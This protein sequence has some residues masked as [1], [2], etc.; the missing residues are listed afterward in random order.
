MLDVYR[1]AMPR[2]RIHVAQSMS[3]IICNGATTVGTN[4]KARAMP[5]YGLVFAVL[6]ND[7]VIGIIAVLLVCYNGVWY[8]RVA[9]VHIYGGGASARA[10]PTNAQRASKCQT[11]L[12]TGNDCRALLDQAGQWQWQRPECVEWLLTTP[13]KVLETNT[14]HGRAT[15]Y[16]ASHLQTIDV[17]LDNND[18]VLSP[19]KVTAPPLLLT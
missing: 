15:A 10:C 8:C 19:K 14:H 12:P 16:S 1:H 6:Y 7:R 18:K 5:V 2:A 11:I 4:I 3:Q 9:G 13:T 17:G